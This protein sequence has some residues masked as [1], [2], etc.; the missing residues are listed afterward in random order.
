MNQVYRI[1]S[2]SFWDHDSEKKALWNKYSVQ[3]YPGEGEKRICLDALYTLSDYP[4]L[5][6]FGL[7]LFLFPQYPVHTI[8]FIFTFL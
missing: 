1:A 2:F 6:Q 4:F 5:S 3:H 7:W 8:T